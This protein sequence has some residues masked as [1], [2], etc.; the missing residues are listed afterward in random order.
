VLGSQKSAALRLRF[1]LLTPR[2]DY[3]VV[4]EPF[5][6]PIPH[7]AEIIST[8]FAEKMRPSLFALIEP[9]APAGWSDCGRAELLLVL[10][11]AVVVLP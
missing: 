4:S 11:A 8:W 10:P 1:L 6:L 5:L 2:S 9:C 7:E 3:F